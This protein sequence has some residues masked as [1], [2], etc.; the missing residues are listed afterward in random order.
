[1][2]STLASGRAH[3]SLRF[4]NLE[5]KSVITITDKDVTKEYFKETGGPD[6]GLYVLDSLNLW[7][8]I[9]SGRRQ[10]KKPR[11]M[12]IAVPSARVGERA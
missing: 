6:T 2:P 7:R 10:G 3:Q 8:Q 11:Q 12:P 9:E 1:M 4:E 5:Q